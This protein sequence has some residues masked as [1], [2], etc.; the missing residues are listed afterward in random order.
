M[1][2]EIANALH[3]TSRVYPKTY[4]LL[5]QGGASQGSS[6]KSNS[7]GIKRKS[8][9]RSASSEARTVTSGENVKRVPCPVCG[10]TSCSK[11]N[12]FLWNHPHANRNRD[13]PWSESTW[14]DI[15]LNKVPG[16]F[17][18]LPKHCIAVV[19]PDGTY[20]TEMWDGSTSASRADKKFKVSNAYYFY[21][22]RIIKPSY[23]CQRQ[24]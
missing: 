12:C 23:L 10:G 19:Q 3:L 7:N 13:I 11:G 20:E 21:N 16:K 2:T 1:C 9:Q 18:Y 6:N 24:R 8:E 14:G 5:K 22:G 17:S 4:H 15:Y